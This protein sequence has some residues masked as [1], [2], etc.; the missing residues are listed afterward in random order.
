MTHTDIP[1]Y[2]LWPLVFISVAIFV[3]FGL[4]FYK[5]RTSRD[6][7]SFGAFTAFLVAMFTEMYGFPLTLY[8]LS[9]WLLK[10]YP[11]IDLLSHQTGHLWE[12]L[13]GSKGDP[14][15]TLLHTLSEVLIVAGFVL[16]GSAWKV[17]YRAQQTGQV[18]TTGLYSHI[19]HP[20]YSGFIVIMF[21]LLLQWPTL[22]T[23]L[24]FP[25]LVIVYTRLAYHEERESEAEF[26]EAYTTYAAQTPAF[27]PRL[28]KLQV[29]QAHV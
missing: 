27:I 10:R 15:F 6:W 13:L 14:H 17:L 20:Q 28:L 1:A 9:G 16:I 18:A 4:S 7:R 19:R 21:G 11:G 2:G 26:G 5:P 23:L 25:I 24:M 12:T 8:I 3:I 29:G 22:I